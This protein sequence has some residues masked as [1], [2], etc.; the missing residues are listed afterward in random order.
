VNGPAAAS[1]VGYREAV[2]SWTQHLRA[3]GATPWSGWTAAPEQSV[4][5]GWTM[6][7]AAQLELVRRL[8]EQGT[9]HGPPF[10][11]LADLALSRSGPGRGLA[12]QP[13]AW[14]GA[15]ASFGPQPTDPADVP[16]EELLRAGVGVLTELLL[17]A[18]P[19]PEWPAPVHRRPGS[20]TPAFELA[21]APVTLSA[22]R[23]GLAR[24]GHVEGGRDPRVV[25]VVEPV[26][27]ALFQ[28]WSA[29]VQA[30]A[31]ARWRGYAHRWAGRRALP[32]SAD[33]TAMARHWAD[34]V[35]ADRVHLVVA[36]APGTVAGRVCAV[37]GLTPSRRV[38]LTGEPPVL[39]L[40]PAAVDVLR[41]VNAVLDVRVPEDDRAAVRRTL[42]ATL[43]ARSAG[44][45]EGLTV[46]P[47][48]RDR[49][50]E[51]AERAV[52]ELTSAGYPVHGR[53]ADAVPRFE[54]LASHPRRADAL[55]LVVDACLT[56]AGVQQPS[57]EE[58]AP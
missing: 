43:A 14:P 40:A 1:P 38:R 19:R 15:T 8:A 6:P 34:R 25:V 10:T 29:R 52:E 33:V 35:G 4:P 56:L 9:R 54:T 7:G 36:T 39:D 26:D 42:G 50:R 31:A 21:G 30:G 41:R 53:L 13:P 37:L 47:Q 57:P 48:L 49:L 44:A 32:P 12:Q 20:R 51:R 45:A 3:G 18:P 5:A 22:V 27:R 23:R 17:D 55:D 24:A 11:G 58:G 16:L 46:P 28:A 2:W